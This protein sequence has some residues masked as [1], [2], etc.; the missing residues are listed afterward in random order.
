LTATGVI[1]K[2]PLPDGRLLISAGR[3]DLAARGFPQ[4]ILTPDVGATVNLDR[5]CGAIAP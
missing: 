2:A 1:A 3:V 5:F 4:F